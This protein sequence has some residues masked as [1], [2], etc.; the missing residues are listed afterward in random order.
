MDIK[1]RELLQYIIEHSTQ[2]LP[3]LQQLVRQTNLS[4][5]Q[6]RMLSGHI[7]GKILEMLCRMIRPNNILEIGTFTGYSAICM[8]QALQGGSQLDTIDPNDEISHIVRKYVDLSGLSHII[9]VH[10]GRAQELAPKLE[11]VYDLV[12]IDGD[13]REYSDYYNMLFDS[14][15]VKSGSFILADN[16][17]WDGKVTDA[18]TH[19]DKHTV[20]V[21]EFNKLVANDSRVEVVI[22]PLRDGISIIR[23]L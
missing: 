16:V 10:N 4:V 11:R 23:V 12:F 20:A 1:E 9:N 6:P 15:L 21:L 8:A 5:V 22:L 13:K 18:Q 14:S 17:L 7:Q 19:K 3:V 2:E